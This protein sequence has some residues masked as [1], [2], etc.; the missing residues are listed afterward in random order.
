MQITVTQRDNVTKRDELVRRLFR[1]STR[2]LPWNGKT[3][4]TWFTAHLKK[5]GVRHRGANQ[6]RRKFAS[7]ALSSYVPAE[8][9]ARQ[10]G[11]DVSEQMGFGGDWGGV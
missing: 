5:A 11:S 3:V 4:S 1:S 10:L 8:W 6:C 9:V 2:G 7:Q